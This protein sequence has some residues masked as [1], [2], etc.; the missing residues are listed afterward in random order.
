[1]MTLRGLLDDYLTT[2]RALGF[3]LTS[4]GT[5]LKTFVSFMEEQHAD[6]ITT[7]LALAWAQQPRSV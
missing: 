1:M 3:K 7:E 4:E 2:R 5:G 6:H